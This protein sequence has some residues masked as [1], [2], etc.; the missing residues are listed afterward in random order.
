[1]ETCFEVRASR[2]STKGGKGA[3]VAFATSHLRENVEQAWKVRQEGETEKSTWDKPSQCVH[4]YAKR[5]RYEQ[6]AYRLLNER[7]GNRKI[8]DWASR[9]KETCKYLDDPAFHVYLF[10]ET[11]NEDLHKEFVRAPDVPLTMDDAFDQAIRYEGI[12]SRE[13]S[14]E[15]I[16]E[17]ATQ[18]NAG[19]PVRTTS[20]QPN[21]KRKRRDEKVETRPPGNRSST[22]LSP[23]KHRR[24][25]DG[26]QAERQ[27]RKEMQTKE[28]RCFVCNGKGHL[29]RD[30]RSRKDG[31]APG[32]ETS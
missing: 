28:G 1:M 4:S 3:R 21:Y 27:K 6:A 18:R 11:L 29:A 19:G 5:E 15:S 8:R 24:Q 23:P 31:E 2:L 16:R 20:H 10:I 30:C 22:G 25:N 9:W 13:R 12:L 32:K 17:A 14:R 26:T 7:Q